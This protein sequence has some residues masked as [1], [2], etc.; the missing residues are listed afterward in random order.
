MFMRGFLSFQKPNKA[1]NFVF[2]LGAG[3]LLCPSWWGVAPFTS[4]IY[5]HYP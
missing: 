1:G 2:A 4:S 3:H 5:R